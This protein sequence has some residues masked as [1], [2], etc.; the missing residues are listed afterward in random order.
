[1]NTD[2]SSRFQALWMGLAILWLSAAPLCAEQFGLF[3]YQVI[4]NTVEITDYPTSETGDVDIPAEIAGKP[5]TSI[6]QS[7]FYNCTGLTGVTI[8]SSVTSIGNG[9]FVRCAGLTSVT[10]PRS[11]TSIG[12]EAF[13]VGTGL[14]SILV[15]AGN[16]DYSSEAGV[17]FDAAK[18]TLI[19]CPLG[20][21]GDYTIP[22]S[23]TSIGDGAF[24]RC[25]ALTSVTIPSSV[26]SFGWRAFRSCSAL[27]SVTI[28]SSVTSIGDD[29][30]GDCTGLTSITISEGV[31]SIG[32]SAFHGCS[33]LTV[34]VF[35]GDVP[36]LGWN[37]FDDTA[38][39]FTIHYISRSTGFTTPTW[40]GYP[41]L[42]LGA[43]P[44]AS[45]T[46]LLGHGYPLN[47]DLHQDTNG[48]GVSLL[49]AFALDLNPNLN[50]ADSQPAPVL[51]GDTLSMSFHAASPGITYTVETST[52][53]QNWGTEE[54]IMSDLGPDNQRT[55]SVLMDSP[56]RFLRLVVQQ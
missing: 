3:T 16:L 26:T 45:E 37:A 30:F 21:A 23:V 47:T 18:T 29:A 11:V 1:M 35:L 44:T 49:M 43:P 48:D 10:I 13:A 55:A 38:P 50:L 51:G 2:P 53:L 36:S 22:S 8:P 25:R 56:Q 40:E 27:T 52:D 5:V 17:L 34:A 46:W 15:D 20:K 19:Q 54:V 32:D 39:G 33:A 7:A 6:G 12:N 31:T 28:P 41:A 42:P 24:E 14:T 4:G 9:A